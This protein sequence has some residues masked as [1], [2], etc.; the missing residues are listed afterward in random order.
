LVKHYE[1]CQFFAANPRLGSSPPDYTRVLAL[2]VLGTRHDRS[3]QESIHMPIDMFIKWKEVKTIKSPTVA[4]V[5]E[6]ITEIV[7]RF[8][9]PNRIITDFRTNFTRREF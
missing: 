1:G 8:G 5:A 3:L 6:F 9:V 2:C 4:K 7:H